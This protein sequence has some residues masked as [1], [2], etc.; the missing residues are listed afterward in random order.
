MGFL[1]TLFSI[2]GL[3]IVI[4]IIIGF[5]V[6]T[7]AP[8]TPPPLASNAASLHAWIQYIIWIM[9]WPVGLWKPPF[10]AGQP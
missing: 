3:L 1:K 6:G 2:T 9:F 10:T 4:Y 5:Y 7:P 8:H